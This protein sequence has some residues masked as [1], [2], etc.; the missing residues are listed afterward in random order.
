M[1]RRRTTTAVT[2]LALC[3]AG[4][5]ETTGDGRG[6]AGPPPDAPRQAVAP[7]GMRL[8]GLGHAAITLPEG[9]GT[10]ATRCGTPT[11][12]T[13]VI[14]V[15]AVP[16]CGA[17]RP[18]DVDSVEITRGRPFDLEVDETF[19][20]GG[21]RAQ[22]QRTTCHGGGFGGA[23]TCVGTV[24]LPSMRVAFR[25]ESSTDDLT[26]D[27]VLD[28]IRIAPEHI[29]VPGYQSIALRRQQHSGQAYVE[30]LRRAGLTPRVRH[31]AARA[32]PAGFVVGVTPRPGTMV[33][34]GTVV[35]VTVVARR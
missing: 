21:V 16:A 2:L 14:D 22:R 6:E 31:R 4:C 32:V 15:G 9:W 17:A 7:P 23:R 33:R 34:P 13:V 29:A 27:R 28:R 25:A 10:N 24:Y 35:T 12:D 18:A 19:S 1:L 5:G 8:V 20:L 30:A 3:A 11:R 26:P